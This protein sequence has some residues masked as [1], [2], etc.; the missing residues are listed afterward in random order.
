MPIR[1]IKIFV[2]ICPTCGKKVSMSGELRLLLS[3]I[4]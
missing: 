3:E 1:K 4:K 2:A